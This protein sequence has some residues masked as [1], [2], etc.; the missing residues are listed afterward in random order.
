MDLVDR[1]KQEPE[2]NKNLSVAGVWGEV[3]YT[4]VG[5]EGIVGNKYLSP[6]G[7]KI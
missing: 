4:D 7:R 2:P 3:T 1:A 5:S 6:A